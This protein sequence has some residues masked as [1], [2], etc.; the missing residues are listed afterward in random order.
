[1]AMDDLDRNLTPEAL[2]ART[3]HGGHATMSDLFQQLVLV[4][5]GKRMLG[6]SAQ[7]DLPPRAAHGSC[8]TRTP[9]VAPRTPTRAP[10][11]MT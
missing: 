2:V 11:T 9:F 3:V 10:Y 8:S 6:R 4:E 7:S 1:V 5:L